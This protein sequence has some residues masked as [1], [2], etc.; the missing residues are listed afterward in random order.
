MANDYLQP[1]GNGTQRIAA[2]ACLM[3][4]LVATATT[5]VVVAGMIQRGR[6]D[7]NGKPLW[8]AAVICGLIAVACGWLTVRLAVGQSKNGVTVLPLWFIEAFGMLFLIGTVWVGYEYG[9]IWGG[10]S[11]VSVAVAMIL[12]RRAVRQREAFAK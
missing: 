8:V 3:A 4:G 7:Y 1:V 5:V 2:I 9:L 11:A 6:L 10:T 12:V